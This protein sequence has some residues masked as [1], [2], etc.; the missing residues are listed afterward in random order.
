MAVRDGEDVSWHKYVKYRDF[1]PPKSRSCSCFF[2]KQ[3]DGNEVDY[4]RILG[5]L[6]KYRAK[7]L[8]YG[9]PVSKSKTHESVACD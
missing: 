3:M 8:R 4:S 1:E 6:L 2:K 5:A 9:A 7:S